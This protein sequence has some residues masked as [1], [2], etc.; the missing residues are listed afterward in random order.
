M[1]RRREQLLTVDCTAYRA[2]QFD[3][4]DRLTVEYNINIPAFVVHNPDLRRNALER[5]R[6]L[7][8]TDFN[9]ADQIYYQITGTYVL[10]NTEN[11]DTCEWVGS[12]YAG[13]HN[14]AVLQDFQLFDRRLFV[15]TVHNL[16]ETVDE[17]LLYNGRDTKWE[18]DSLQSIIINVQSTVVERHRVIQQRRL[19]QGIRR[20]KFRQTFDLA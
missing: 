4:N 9:P 20:R 1:L 15:N 5:V 8:E 18:F 3:H 14:P 17:Q 19:K 16:L 12:F 6:V 11:N 2:V 10:R 7:L 13:L